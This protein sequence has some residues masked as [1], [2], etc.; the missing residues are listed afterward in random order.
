MGKKSKVGEYFIQLMLVVVGVF[1]GLLASDWSNSKQLKNN[2]DEVLQNIK[3]EIESNIAIVERAQKNRQRF[4]KSL[5]SIYPL[6]TKDVL[7]ELLFDKNFGERFPNWRGV[8]NGQLSNAMFE[9]AKYSNLLSGMDIQVAS[10][11]SKTYAVQEGH[12]KARETF[13]NKFFDFNSKTTYN[14]AMRI[15]FAVRQELS[16][17]ENVLIKEYKKTLELL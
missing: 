6:L 3:L 15:M 7:N 11:L 13:L 5:D 2:Q 14:D 16:S 1:L 4:N 10:Q 12:D 17:F 9:M 8:G